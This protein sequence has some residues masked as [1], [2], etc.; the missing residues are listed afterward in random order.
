MTNKFI[1]LTTLSA[2]II[3]S[4]LGC[5]SGTRGAPVAMGKIG[6]IGMH[7]DYFSNACKQVG[8]FFLPAST[9]SCERDDIYRMTQD[10]ATSDRKSNYILVTDVDPDV[11][12]ARVTTFQCVPEYGRPL[13][14]NRQECAGKNGNA[15]FEAA[16][17]LRRIA[18]QQGTLLDDAV[19]GTYG[20][21]ARAKLYQQ[22]CEYGSEAGCEFSKKSDS[23]LKAA[24]QLL[25][26]EQTCKIDRKG[27]AVLAS[28]FFDSGD[29][30]SAEKYS[31]LGCIAEEKRSCTIREISAQ[32]LAEDSANARAE[33]LRMI[34]IIQMRQ[35]NQEKF[36]ERFQGALNQMAGKGSKSNCVTKTNSLGEIVT[37]CD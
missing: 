4:L 23:Q 10:I 9:K 11:C 31:A 28:M 6:I 27:C 17:Q 3:L 8:K 19:N 30:K 20:I 25:K 29:M 35:A 32:R 26:M 5:S 18:E 37:H 2:F 24:K 15:C 36:E 21:Q 7:T 16:L 13:A 33:S 14:K 34:Q 22:S 1:A 12:A